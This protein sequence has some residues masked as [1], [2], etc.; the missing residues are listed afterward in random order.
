MPPPRK[1]VHG[2]SLWNPTVPHN[3]EVGEKGT[4]STLLKDYNK[5]IPFPSISNFRPTRLY[6]NRLSKRI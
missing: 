5:N 6:H 2:S 1:S 3:S 4:G